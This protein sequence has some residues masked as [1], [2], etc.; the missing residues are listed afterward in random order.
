MLLSFEVLE[1]TDD[2]SVPCL[3]ENHHLLH[4]LF[5]LGLFAKMGFVYTFDCYEKLGQLLLRQIHF[6]EGALAQNFSDAVK[7]NC[8]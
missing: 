5:R 3:F 1:E 8:G 7:F 6:A 2:V 4:H